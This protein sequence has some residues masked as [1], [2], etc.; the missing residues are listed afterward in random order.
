M[1]ATL[2][3]SLPEER[4]EFKLAINAGVYY[5]ALHDLDTWLRG[6]EK[7]TDKTT[8]EIVEVRFKIAEALTE[9]E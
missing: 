9:L 4:E 8:V 7:H 1:K 6:L 3:F 5:S 2:K